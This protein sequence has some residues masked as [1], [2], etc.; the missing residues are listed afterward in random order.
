M[1]SSIYL[2]ILLLT[3]LLTANLYSADPVM[4]KDINP[5]GSSNPRIINP[6]GDYIIFE[7]NDG[8]NGIEK[9]MSDGT[10]SGTWLL[11]DINPN[12]D[13]G[14]SFPDGGGYDGTVFN[15]EYYFNGNNGSD[16]Y[17]LWKTDGTESG[18]VMVK[19]IYSGSPTSFPTLANW[20]TVIYNNQLIFSAYKGRDNDQEPFKT[21]GTE[22]GT[23]MIKDICTTR[24]SI[25]SMRFRGSLPGPYVVLGD[26]F[27]FEA[28][29]GETTRDLMY[30]S[31]GTESGTVL[32]LDN[33]Q[34]VI[35]MN[36]QIKNI[37]NILYFGGWDG[38]G[39]PALW[40]SDGTSAGTYIISTASS[41]QQPNTFV[42]CGNNILFVWSN[43]AYGN[44]LWKTDGTESGT[45]M[46]KEINPTTESS[47]NGNLNHHAVMND[48]FY[49]KGDDGTNGWAL[50]R[51]DG[52]ANGTYMVKD[53]NPNSSEGTG[54]WHFIVIGNTLYFSADDGNGREL[55]KSDGSTAG[56]VKIS[57]INQNG[58]ANVVGLTL[59]NGVIYFSADDGTNGVE[60]WKYDP[61]AVDDNTPPTAICQDI[62]VNLDAS[63]NATI[64][65][66][67]IDNGSYDETGGSGLGN[68]SLSQTDFDCTDA[69]NTIEVTLTVNDNSGNSSTCTA[70]VTVQDN[71]APTA[72]GKDITVNLDINGS[73]TI[74]ADDVDDG[75]YDNCNFT[76]TLS[77]YTFTAVNSYTVTLT[78]DDGTNTPSTDDVTVTVEAYQS[79]TEPPTISVSLSKTQLW[80]IN[81]RMKSI[82]ATVTVS[83]NNPEV[84]FVLTS[85]TS[86]QNESGLD[87]S[88]IA[89]DIQNE[90]TGTA[91]T[92]FDLRAE[93]FGSDRIYTIVYTATDA[94]GNT[95]TSTTHVTAPI[96][97]GKKGV[98]EELTG[99]HLLK[100][101]PNP[102]DDNLTLQL[103]LLEARNIEIKIFDLP[104]T[105]LYSMTNAET[106][107][108]NTS[109]DT[110]NLNPGTYF[111]EIRVGD[112]VIHRKFI[113]K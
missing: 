49:F 21:D 32:M 88:D 98:Y 79:D 94:A 90:V 112:N 81:Q 92:G 64:T 87:A 37:D 41:G 6:F 17:E 66:S 26:Y 7:A 61:N 65:A 31:D 89:D 55:W 53:C 74:T 11:K 29:N 1:K 95:A 57:N 51:S 36:G 13:G 47:I 30:R 104:G 86:N 27:Y 44:E 58:D 71:T 107:S 75:S 76:K 2:L 60:L 33:N 28:H 84:T 102:V 109:I 3:F 72:I 40:R 38:N 105:E 14:A 24:W 73:V 25:G 110:Q 108:I 100:I 99:V 10:E 113:K 42:K 83:D 35:N 106:N 39:Y 19:D 67:Q 4:V 85:I 34:E 48:V 62:T 15:N 80:P 101:F 12:G 63:G 97:K 78:I 93:R 9:W 16:G 52:T 46:V 23:V 91:D 56:T 43:G 20:Y 111:I 5:N 70:N 96:S 68:M 18:T 103:E 54:P 22:S 45:L 82:N 77:Q 69:G 59:F 8:T 50:W